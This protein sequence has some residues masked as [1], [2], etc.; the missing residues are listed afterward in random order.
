MNDYYDIGINDWYYIFTD[1]TPNY[2]VAAS[3]CCNMVEK[4][5]KSVVLLECPKDTPALR[6]HNLAAINEE[7]KRCGVD[8]QLDYKKLMTLKSYYYDARYPG[9]NYIVV[10]KE[11]FEDCVDCA[12]EVL[13]AVNKYRNEHGLTT[14]NPPITSESDCDNIWVEYC[15]RYGIS[16]DKEIDEECRLMQM[17][18]CKGKE[19]YAMIKHDFL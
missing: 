16:P 5:L 8:L 19:L 1:D 3:N 11:L 2:N 18:K 17:Y 13:N 14:I 9:D 4:F 12:I 7:L 6:S 15:R 10:T